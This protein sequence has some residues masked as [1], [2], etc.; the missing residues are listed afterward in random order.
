MAYDTIGRPGIAE[1]VDGILARHKD[2]SL[3]DVYARRAIATFISSY[4]PDDFLEAND[5]D[6]LEVYLDITLQVSRR[7]TSPADAE[8]ANRKNVI[9]GIALGELSALGVIR[10]MGT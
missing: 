7:A 8:I 10:A 4:A 6:R 5:V 2:G 9:A 1:I 3:T